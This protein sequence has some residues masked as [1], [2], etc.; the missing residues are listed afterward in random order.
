[1]EKEISKAITIEISNPEKLKETTEEIKK[2]G[3]DKLHILTDFDRTLTTA[4]VDGKSMPSL[5]SIL[6]DGNYLTPDYAAKAH[7]LYNHYAPIEKDLS[8]PFAERKKAME[9][10]WRT[11]FKLLIKSGLTKSEMDKAIGSGK[12]KFRDGVQQ[13][14]KTLHKANVPVIIMSSSAL[15]GEA[16]TRYLKKSGHYFDNIKVISNS[17]NWDEQGVATSV[18]EPIIHGLGKDETMIKDF[19]F[20]DDVKKRPNVILL[21]DS[22]GDTGMVEGFDYNNLI[23]IGFLNE[24]VNKH[25]EHFKKLYD[26]TITNDGTFEPVNNLLSKILS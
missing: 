20:F 4:K 5:I 17:F 14:L 1:M 11:H 18:Q 12:I 21:G 6:R 23:K 13:F 26:I 3:P 15:G 22:E 8:I 25:I 24:D 16:I 19:P 10:W 2:D 9:E 7:A